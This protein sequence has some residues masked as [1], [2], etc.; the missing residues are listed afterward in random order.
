M[1]H[2]TIRE[3]TETD[4]AVIRA[5]TEAAFHGRPYAGGDEQDVIDRLRGCSGLTL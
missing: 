2:V 4:Q 5:L 3:E 1:A